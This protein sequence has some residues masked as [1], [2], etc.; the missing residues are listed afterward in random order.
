MVLDVGVACNICLAALQKTKYCSKISAEK[1][2][3]VGSAFPAY[4]SRPSL[5][6]LQKFLIGIGQVQ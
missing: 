1:Y 6:V 5:R 2:F 4:G 3:S